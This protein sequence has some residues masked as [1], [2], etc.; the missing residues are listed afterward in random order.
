MIIWCEVPTIS[1]QRCSVI[2]HPSRECADHPLRAIR[3]ITDTVLKQL[4]R[5]FSEIYSDIGRRSI[6]PE[7]LLGAL[8]NDKVRSKLGIGNA[9]LV[10]GTL[11]AALRTVRL[12]LGCQ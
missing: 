10:S 1:N 4:S 3:Q 12:P 11:V 8:A 5:L 9:T 2:C 7:K 6:A